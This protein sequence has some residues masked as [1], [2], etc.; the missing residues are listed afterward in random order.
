MRASTRRVI[1]ILLSALL[2]IATLG[3]YA[4]LIRPK[5]RDVAE[6]RA[7]VHS[8]RNTFDAQ[9]SAVG[10]VRALIAQVRGAQQAQQGI[11]LVMPQNP[12]LTQ[13]LHQLQAI[14]RSSQVNIVS[15]TTK[16]LPFESSNSPLIRRLGS[17]ESTAILSG[18]YE[19]LR[20][21]MKAFETNV[22]VFNVKEFSVS[23][24]RSGDGGVA[25]AGDNFFTAKVVADLYYQEGGTTNLA[26][27]STQA[28]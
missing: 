9:K 14:A 18:S 8:K 26:A 11:A 7:I 25:S 13:A 2:L 23:S 17:F 12:A 19:S 24:N 21:F 20:N 27:T 4:N 16:P 10:R 1:S 28:R 15:F 22:R 3:V 5:M 6:K